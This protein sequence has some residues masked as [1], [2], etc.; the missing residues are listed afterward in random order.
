M[1]EKCSQGN[2]PERCCVGDPWGTFDPYR[3]AEPL[4]PYTIQIASQTG[5]DPHD[6]D[7]HIEAEHGWEAHNPGYEGT[8]VW[9][10]GCLL[11]GGCDLG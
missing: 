10:A 9:A 5:V 2:V 11:N 1:G 4:H 8:V 3:D 7:W 6:L